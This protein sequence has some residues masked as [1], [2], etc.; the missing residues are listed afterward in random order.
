MPA[1]GPEQAGRQAE[2]G[3]SH[4]RRA[5]ID[6]VDVD[7]IVRQPQRQ[8]HEG[9]KDEEV[10]HRKPPDLQVLQWCKLLRQRRRL[11]TRPALFNQRRVVLGKQE[12]QHADDRKPRGP[13]IGNPVPAVGD[14]HEGGHELGDRRADVA[15]PENPKRRALMARIIPTA[16]I[17]HTDDERP[18]SQPDAKRRHQIHGIGGGQRQRPGGQGR[19]YHLG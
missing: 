9:A 13:D 19:Q 10:V 3:R 1:I 18:A 17:G 8:R 12:E 7:Q 14:H 2:R 5:H 11:G 4:A 6:G 15:R 16:D